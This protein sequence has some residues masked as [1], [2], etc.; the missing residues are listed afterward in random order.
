MGTLPGV[1]PS[2]G[3]LHSYCSS[4]FAPLRKLLAHLRF[5]GAVCILMQNSD[6]VPVP[7]S[8]RSP[9]LLVFLSSMA[10]TT[11]IAVLPSKP[12]NMG[13]L[14]GQWLSEDISSLLLC[15]FLWSMMPVSGTYMGMSSNSHRLFSTLRF[16]MAISFPHIFFVIPSL[17]FSS[18]LRSYL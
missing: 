18:P 8:P 2:A 4:S 15:S 12:S 10:S 17:V 6:H 13:E 5:H 16:A 11:T 9:L 1:I 7:P 3:F 14:A